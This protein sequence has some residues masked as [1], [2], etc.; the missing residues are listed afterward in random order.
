VSRLLALALTEDERRRADRISEIAPR[1]AGSV[2]ELLSF[3]DDSNWVVRRA[4]VSALAAT[5]EPALPRLAELLEHV[6]DSERRIAATVDAL[7]AS[8][9][10]VEPVALRLAD[11]NVPA[12]VCD[13]LQILGRRRSAAAVPRLAQLVEAAD[14]NVALA[15]I[16][17][18]GRVG[19]EAAIT[20]LL[21]VVA[22]R[23]FFRAFPAVD[24]LGRSANVRAIKPLIELLR[25]PHY[26]AEAARALGRIGDAAALESL[27]SLLTRP[28]DAVV[29]AA[30][31]ALSE[32]H[33]RQSE[34]FG[35]ARAVVAALAESDVRTA[36]ARVVHCLSHADAS[37]Q[38]ALVRVLSWLGGEP[39]VMALT[40]LLGAEHSAAQSA[41]AALG[42]LGKEAEPHL[43]AA[44]RVADSEHRL[45]ILPLLSHKAAS[46]EPVAQ[47]LTDPNPTVRA[48]ACD[49]LAR[50]GITTIV[51]RL[52]ELLGDTD[53]R[54]SQSAIAA[55]QSLGTTETQ[56]L[57][58]NAARSPD[59]RTRRAGLR[60]VAYFGYIAALD[61]LIEAMDDP[62]ERIR[63]A[64]IAGL[65]YI[66]SP[67]AIEALL[68]AATHVSARTRSST[69]R[70]LGQ[71]PKQPRT[72]EVLRAA[73]RDPEPWVRYFACQ[74]LSRLKDE[75]S[76]DLI[77]GLVTDP[78]GQVRVAVVEALAQLRGTH[79]LEALHRAATSAEADV[80][81]AA[82]LGLGHVKDLSSLPV[83]RHALV[84]ADAATR[85]VAA[86]SLAEFDLPEVAHDLGAALSD[87]D[88]S[89]R[90]AAVSLLASRTGP[91][92][93]R[94][95]I[96]HLSVGPIQGRVLAALALPIEGRA[97]ELAQALKTATPDVVPLVVTALAR[98]SRPDTIAVLEEQFLSQGVTGRR[99]IAQALAALGA[100]SSRPLLDR[101][102]KDDPD[103][104]VRTICAA[105]VA[106]PP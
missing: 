84:G 47:C 56:R 89:V 78:A 70:A 105:A 30:A 64:A 10:D 1:G 17:A 53:A 36:T 101:A 98:A 33:D 85:L 91:D 60:I 28:V 99:A 75:A 61:V 22:S 18:L 24:V 58:L 39:A 106:G 102:A 87:A 62:D 6:R 95:L 38:S 92:A 26:A 88:D 35:S 27:V 13:A 52:F 76:S 66:D 32:I 37:E 65:P 79:A 12:V 9:G 71:A 83:L 72:I 57:A 46:A 93:T 103:E 69:V 8:R 31:L 90:S 48:L 19:D 29:R 11:S 45:L 97:T 7:V 49:A 40:D 50:I 94:T 96:A 86:S 16:E 15:A 55:I 51:P 20:P 42:R 68:R 80:Q 74:A 59:A 63:E 34:R 100:G 77:A 21:A 73:L 5:G 44:L 25:E 81:R 43:L 54:V 41:A 4:A 2:N 82:L 23:N 14:D 3:L 104:E 67:R